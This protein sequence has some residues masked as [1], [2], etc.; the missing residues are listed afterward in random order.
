MKNS[1]NSHILRH[2]FFNTYFSR[3]KPERPHRTLLN[4]IHRNYLLTPVLV[5]LNEL[6]E[7]ILFNFFATFCFLGVA[8]CGIIAPLC[9]TWIDKV[10]RHS[11]HVTESDT[12]LIRRKKPNS[13]RFL[14]NICFNKWWNFS[15]SSKY[16]NV[17]L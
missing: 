17:Y 15:L 10:D 14:C 2:T 11:R 4:V 3:I 9:S 1:S 13:T 5:R 16:K 6:Q 12:C 7:L 8:H